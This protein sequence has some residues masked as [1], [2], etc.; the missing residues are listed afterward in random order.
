MRRDG[1]APTGTSLDRA[2]GVDPADKV[3]GI[4]AP[5]VSVPA[6]F[7]L[8]GFLKL[9]TPLLTASTP[10]NAVHPEANAR[11]ARRTTASPVAEVG[12]SI[13]YDADSA[14]GESPV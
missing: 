3:A 7:L 9:G 14:T 2:R 1:A 5:I 4:A 10:V 8:L 13:R 6:A 12:G 11:M